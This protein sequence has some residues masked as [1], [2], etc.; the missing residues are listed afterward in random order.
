[1]KVSESPDK[2]SREETKD[3]SRAQSSSSQ[4]L[5]VLKGPRFENMM[6]SKGLLWRKVNTQIFFFFLAWVASYFF[7][8]INLF[9]FGCI[10]SLLLHAGFLQLHRAG[11]TLHC[12]ARASHCS[13]FSC[14]GARAPGARA[15]VVVACGLQQLWLAG[16]RAQAQ[17]LWHTGLVAPRHVGSSQAR[18]RTHVLC[19]G[20]RILNHCATRE[21]LNTQ[22]LHSNSRSV[23]LPVQ[24]H[25]WTPGPKLIQVLRNSRSKATRSLRFLILLDVQTWAAHSLRKGHPGLSSEVLSFLLVLNNPKAA[26]DSGVY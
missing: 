15:S 8:L 4:L 7:F 1:M 5:W 26:L 9:I 18:D 23:Q 17:Q 14:C 21:V 13:G 16:S 12:G 3:S 20:R 22:I 10:G 19:I 2:V 25:A 24:T 11:A 6:K